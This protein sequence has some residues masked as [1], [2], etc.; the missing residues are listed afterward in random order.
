M[1]EKTE[2]QPASKTVCRSPTACLLSSRTNSKLDLIVDFG[3]DSW[4]QYR[5]LFNWK[6]FLGSVG[7]FP[8]VEDVLVGI[9]RQLLANPITY[10]SFLISLFL[11]HRLIFFS[12]PQPIIFTRSD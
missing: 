10:S 5:F 3:E 7:F 12:F 8:H 11:G 1:E 6:V 4:R 9:C 2:A